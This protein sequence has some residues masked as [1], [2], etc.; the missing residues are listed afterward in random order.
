MYFSVFSH[1]LKVEVFRWN[2][3]FFVVLLNFCWRIVLFLFSALT[4]PTGLPVLAVLC[5]FLGYHSTGW[6]LNSWWILKGSMI[7]NVFITSAALL[8]VLFAFLYVSVLRKLYVL[9]QRSADKNKAVFRRYVSTDI[10]RCN[11][12]HVVNCFGRGVHLTG[13]REIDKTMC[14]N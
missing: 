11:I 5:N 9:S 12:S 13:K 3:L 1:Y 4:Q 14:F 8:V 2:Y 7:F 6:N 10:Y